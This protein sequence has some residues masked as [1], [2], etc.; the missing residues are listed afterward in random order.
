MSTS[1]LTKHQSL[2]SAA[3]VVKRVAPANYYAVGVPACNTL[4]QATRHVFPALQ[5]AHPIHLARD[6]SSVKLERRADLA[7]LDVVTVC[8][9]LYGQKT[10]SSARGAPLVGLL[11]KTEP[12]C[13]VQLD[14][15]GAPVKTRAYRA[16]Q[17]QSRAQRRIPAPRAD[18]AHTTAMG[19]S[20]SAAYLAINQTATKTTV[21]RA[22]RPA[23]WRFRLLER[24]AK[25]AP[26]DKYQTTRGPVAVVSQART[27][28]TDTV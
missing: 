16:Q 1:G 14:G 10:A 13:S 9:I 6:V 22:L 27:T 19:R 7:I 18:T 23:N 28:N 17:D 26:L 5:A 24:R 3:P 2:A 25:N 20:A 15:Q 11:A 12:A 4:D 8:R 21:S